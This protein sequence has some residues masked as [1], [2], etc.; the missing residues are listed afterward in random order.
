MGWKNLKGM[1]ESIRDEG[2][3]RIFSFRKIP[4][5]V[6][7]AGN[8]YDLSMSPGNP[9]PNYYTGSPLTATL[10]DSKFSFQHG[11]N[12][13]PGSKHL[14]EV[15]IMSTSATGLPVEFILCDYLLFY[16]V[17]DQ[18]ETEAQVMDNTITIPRYASGE[19]VRVM[20]V[21]TAP[22][23]GATN[24]RFNM[25]YVNSHDVEN[26]TTGIVC[27][28]A[29]SLGTIL[30]TQTALLDAIGP[31]IKLASGD[32]GIKSITS[33]TVTTNEVGLF[34]LVLV[35][36]I[37]SFMLREQTA[38]VEVCF[39]R[40]RPS[41]PKIEDGAVLNLIAMPSGNFTGVAFPGLLTTCW[42]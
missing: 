36:P 25:T 28:T 21:M 3:Q 12:V 33:V 14:K 41:M 7:V 8:W 38:P 13:S 39:L 15:L 31:F 30:T 17:I 19:G 11:G 37:A 16:S 24:A 2:K 10:L 40:D 23:S 32:T 5:Q 29:N 18:G 1:I 35:K 42:S 20:A 26:T 27:T 22:A 34:A 9:N 4:S 6:H